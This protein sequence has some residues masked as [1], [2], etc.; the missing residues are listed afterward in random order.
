M[1]VFEYDHVNYKDLAESLAAALGVTI[2]NNRVN[3]PVHIAKG[4]LQLVE[5]QGSLQATVFEFTFMDQFR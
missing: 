1:F 5:L 4:Y 3:Y 2:K